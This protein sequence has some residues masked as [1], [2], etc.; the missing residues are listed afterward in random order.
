MGLIQVE[1]AEMYEIKLKIKR[2]TII[3]RKCGMDQICL[4]FADLTT[5]APG[6]GHE[7]GAVIYVQAGHAK[8]WLALNGFGPADE[9]IASEAP[10]YD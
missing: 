3:T 8:E 6:L 2:S 10:S 9:I 1:E 5:V 4:T 7:A